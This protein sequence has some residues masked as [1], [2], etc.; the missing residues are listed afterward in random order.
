LPRRSHDL[1]YTLKDR[2]TG[3]VFFVVVVTLILKE[4]VERAE[5]EA[6]SESHKESDVGKKEEKSNNDDDDVD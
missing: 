2:K 3:E 5:A 4:D 6:K 1:R